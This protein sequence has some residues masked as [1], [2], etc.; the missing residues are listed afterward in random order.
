MASL[1]V[2]G[3]RRRQRRTRAKANLPK[4]APACRGKAGH[5][6]RE[7][8]LLSDKERDP[9]PGRPEMTGRRGVGT[10]LGAGRDVPSLTLI[11]TACVCRA[12]C[13]TASAPEGRTHL[14]KR[15]S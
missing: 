10:G 15:Q 9:D 1:M 4:A 12:S 14:S 8:T 6:E 7:K 11:P 2:H 3:T 13:V 5:Q